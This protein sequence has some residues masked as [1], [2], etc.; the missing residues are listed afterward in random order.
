MGTSWGIVLIV[1]SLLAWGGQTLSW[2]RPAVAERLTLTEREETVEPAYYA[3]IRG[4]ALWDALTLWILLVAG[5][6]LV[7]DVDSWAYWGLVGSGVY[8]YFAGRGI[9][10]RRAMQRRGLPIGAAQNITA[11]Y[12]LLA[13]WGAAALI[14]IPAAAVALTSP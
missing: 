11:A 9:V 12:A 13:V 2:L 4:E 10:T 8:L 5:I 14:T 6:L 7:A 3:D 1:L